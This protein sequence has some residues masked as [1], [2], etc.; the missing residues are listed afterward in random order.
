MKHKTYK[1]KSIVILPRTMPK[2]KDVAE[3][4]CMEAQYLY[5][6]GNQDKR[7]KKKVVLMRL[8]LMKLRELQREQGII[9]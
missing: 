6:M 7:N 5:N 2:I 9:T 4:L 3:E 8:G 1:N